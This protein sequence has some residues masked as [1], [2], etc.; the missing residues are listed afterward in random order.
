[1]KALDPASYTVDI[2]GLAVELPLVP[3][4]DTLAISLL[5]DVDR[6]VH[7]LDHIG[8]NLAAVFA[9]DKPDIVV[10]TATLGIPVAIEVSRYLGL[11]RYLILQKSPK[12][13]LQDALV[14]HL[15]SIA[16]VGTQRLLLDR[17][18]IPLLSGRRVLMVDDVIATGSSLAASIRLVRKAGG[19]IVG[20][21]VILTEAHDWRDALGED[22]ALVKG[23]GHIPQ[24]R[25]E[26]GKATIIPSSTEAAR[27]GAK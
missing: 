13:H 2:A 21:G 16:S 27:P 3:V 11:D 4:S 24:F 14:E 20:I 6:G 7:F 8:K 18:A 1:M 12:V 5:I 26:N 19:N 25:I 17:Q 23:L 9:A 15:Q 22:A 10:G